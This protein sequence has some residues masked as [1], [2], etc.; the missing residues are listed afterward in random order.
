MRKNSAIALAGIL[1]LLALSP[2]AAAPGAFG[3]YEYKATAVTVVSRGV[4]VPA[5][6]TV[7]VSADEFPLVVMAHGHGGSKDENGGFVSIAEALAARGVASIRMDFP[8]CGDSKEAFTANNVSNMVADFGAAKAYAVANARIAVGA[9]GAFGYSMGGR[10]AILSSMFSYKSLGLLAPVGTDGSDSMFGFMGGQP[11]Y[12][13]LA[14]A[15][16]ADG[17]VLFTTPFGQVQDLGAKWF[18]DNEA[19]KGLKSIGGFAGK[20]LF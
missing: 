15:A 7:P 14:T 11:K 17:H 8:G 12:A 9:I 6:L 13:E 18:A 10:V 1:L 16:K 19:A 4:N 5:V 3:P 2:A 20:V